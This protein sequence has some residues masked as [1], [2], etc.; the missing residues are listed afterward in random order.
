MSNDLR[1][2]VLGNEE[3]VLRNIRKISKL[4]RIIA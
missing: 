3:L 2:K 4:H 1:L